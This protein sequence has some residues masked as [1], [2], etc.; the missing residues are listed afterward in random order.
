[1]DGTSEKMNPAI[2][3]WFTVRSN[4]AGVTI[5]TS[6][7]SSRFFRQTVVTVS[8]AK[9]MT[10]SSKSSNPPALS[11]TGF[12]RLHDHRYRRHHFYS[13][14]PQITLVDVLAMQAQA[15]S[16][17]SPSG[18]GFATISIWTGGDAGASASS[19]DREALALAAMLAVL[20]DGTIPANRHGDTGY[21]RESPDRSKDTPDNP[22]SDPSA[23]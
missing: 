23:Q 18:S 1:M 9:T 11:H 4:K 22:P 7:L 14:P 3:S 10:F 12:E 5:T 19:E 20:Y 21:G 6:L 8:K 13:T 2:I 16:Q 15:Q 17:A